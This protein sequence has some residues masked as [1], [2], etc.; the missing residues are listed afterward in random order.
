MLSRV[1]TWRICDLVRHGV[2]NDLEETFGSGRGNWNF[3]VTEPPGTVLFYHEKITTVHNTANGIGRMKLCIDCKHYVFRDLCGHPNFLSVVNGQPEQYAN[4]V[5]KFDC[6]V[7]SLKYFEP[8]VPLTSKAV[9]DSDPQCT[10]ADCPLFP[11]CGCK[12]QCKSVKNGRK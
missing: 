10:L 6:G 7:K 2:A 3:T 11:T 4:T 12:T 9:P 1:E 5:R 8:R